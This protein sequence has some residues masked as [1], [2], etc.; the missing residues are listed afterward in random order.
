MESDDFS[1]SNS[2]RNMIAFF[3]SYDKKS[4]ET[5]LICRFLFTAENQANINK[6]VPD[7]YEFFPIIADNDYS[8]DQIFIYIYRNQ[9]MICVQER[10]TT[11]LTS[12]N[13]DSPCSMSK[14]RMRATQTFFVRSS[15]ST[16]RAAES[17]QHSSLIGDH[18]RHLSARW[19]TD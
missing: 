12:V 11:T 6:N 9:N 3:T 1:L 7:V 4:E 18:P 8:E 2:I 19:S 10:L 15:S 13:S 16:D 17:D 5:L 14:T